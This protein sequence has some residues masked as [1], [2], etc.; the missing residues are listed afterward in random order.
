MASAEFAGSGGVSATAERFAGASMASEKKAAG[1]A[2]LGDAPPPLMSSD[3]E[4]EPD[5]HAMA[6]DDNWHSECHIGEEGRSSEKKNKKKKNKKQRRREAALAIEAMKGMNDKLAVID[7][8][9]RNPLVAQWFARKIR[10]DDEFWKAY[11]TEKSKASASSSL[12]TGL[13]GVSSS[14]DMSGANWLHTAAQTALVSASKDEVAE[15]IRLGLVGHPLAS[16]YCCR[17]DFVLPLASW[18]T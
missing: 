6:D 9:S 10:N 7:Y 4:K 15:A 3:N 11:K 8:L 17:N 16:W 18:A 1:L 2:E 12:P 13:S 5:K 14:W